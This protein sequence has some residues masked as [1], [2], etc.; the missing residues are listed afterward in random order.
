MEKYPIYEMSGEVFERL[1]VDLLSTTGIYSNLK[2]ESS[3][4]ID[5]GYDIIGE[6]IGPDRKPRKAIIQVKHRRE[7]NAR[8]I[9]RDIKWASKI[10]GGVY[11]YVLV[12][13]SIAPPS[14]SGDTLL[15]EFHDVIEKFTIIDRKTIISLLDKNPLI[16]EK[17]FAPLK[18]R[19][20][21]SKIIQWVSIIASLS[22]I[23]SFFSLFVISDSRVEDTPLK[24]KMIVVEKALD[25]LKD[26]EHN[27]EAVK[28]E[29]QETSSKSDRIKKEYEQALKLKDVTEQQL[30][31]FRKALNV[32][33]TQRTIFK[34]VLG[35][36][37]GFA[38]SLLASISYE[39]WKR[40]KSL[41]KA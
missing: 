23:F 25:G 20:K 24:N 8:A 16:V 33:D 15:K 28:R 37:F 2:L 3:E 30:E 19:I 7:F 27:L 5:K 17:Y 21:T 6:G 11:E 9:R 40:Y 41:T 18:K 38:S 36:I 22:S 13:S 14:F 12:T 32:E 26:L 39:K 35:F 34:Y 4:G 1:V 10:S 31:A 29:L